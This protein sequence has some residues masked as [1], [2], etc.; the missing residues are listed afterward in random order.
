MFQRINNLRLSGRR[1]FLGL[2]YCRHTKPENLLR[3]VIVF[4]QQLFD[5][6][7]RIRLIM[8]HRA[9]TVLTQANVSHRPLTLRGLCRENYRI[10]TF[11][12][13][14]TNALKHGYGQTNIT[15]SR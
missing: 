1:M 5:R 4:F 13:L 15:W 2:V 6:V 8:N 7:S 14:R 11:L 9:R 3:Y 12:T 10:S